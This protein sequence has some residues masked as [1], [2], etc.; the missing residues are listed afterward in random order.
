MVDLPKYFV[1]CDYDFIATEEIHQ[2]R[3]LARFIN[4]EFHPK[5]II[6]I[7]CGPGIYVQELRKIGLEAIGI[8]IDPRVDQSENLKRIDIASEEFNLNNFS[9]S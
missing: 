5:T 4:N 2:A 6:D 1:P 9:T 3:S 8:D 7:G